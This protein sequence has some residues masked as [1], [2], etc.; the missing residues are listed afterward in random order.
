MG[1]PQ[2]TLYKPEGRTGPVRAI[3]RGRVWR[4]RLLLPRLIR[5]PED[6]QSEARDQALARRQSDRPV[7]GGM[8]RGQRD[9]ADLETPRVRPASEGH[10]RRDGHD[11]R[12]PE[13]GPDLPWPARRREPAGR[14]V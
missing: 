1:I 13:A 11:G 8:V 6:R 12:G 10:L 3:G 5:T 7:H 9:G 14:L 4:D 2:L